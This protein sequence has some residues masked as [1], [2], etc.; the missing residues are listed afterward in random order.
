MVPNSAKSLA[1]TNLFSESHKNIQDTLPLVGLLFGLHPNIILP[2]FVHVEE[3]LLGILLNLSD[4]YLY[5]LD[6]EV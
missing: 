5:N 2:K 1:I 4:S 6:D 3:H